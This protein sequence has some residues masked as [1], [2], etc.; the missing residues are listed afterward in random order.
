MTLS[1]PLPLGLGYPHDW[2][3]VPSTHAPDGDPLDTFIIWEGSGYPGVAL[4]CRPIGVLRVEQTNEKSRRERNDRVAVVPSKA[5]RWDAVHSVFDLHER[6]RL[7]LEQFFTAVTAFE[8]KEL[9]ILGWPAGAK[10]WTWCAPRRSD[11]RATGADASHVLR[12]HW[13][14][15]VPVPRALRSVGRGCPGAAIRKQ[16]SSPIHSMMPRLTVP[17]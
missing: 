9:T 6:V 11:S 2:G 14:N 1:R 3:F 8:G 5:A 12:R 16:T 10:R 13:L 17:A 4:A 15:V 7:E